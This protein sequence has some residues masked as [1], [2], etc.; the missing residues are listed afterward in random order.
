MNR[1]SLRKLENYELEKYKQLNEAVLSNQKGSD[2]GDSMKDTLT[3][4]VSFT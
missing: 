2:L 3:E 4:L 1:N